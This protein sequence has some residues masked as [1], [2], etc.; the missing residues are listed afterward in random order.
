MRKTK[1]VIVG[2]S[3]GAYGGIE[4]FV[5]AVAAAIRHEPDMEV[6]LCL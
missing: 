6:R 2:P 4:A 5:L 3:L 1:V